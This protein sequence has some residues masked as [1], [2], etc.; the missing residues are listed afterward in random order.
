M[1]RDAQS[2]AVPQVLLHSGASFSAA[3]DNII[4]PWVT[5]VSAVSW[6]QTRPAAVL[7]PSSSYAI[8]LRKLVLERG[9]ALLGVHFITPTALRET[10]LRGTKIRIPAS[11][12]LRLLLSIV[13]EQQESLVAAKSVARSPDHLLRAIEQIGAAG[14]DF[15]KVGPSDLR[16]I[17]KHFKTLVEQCGFQ[18]PYQADRQILSAS[19]ERPVFSD[20]LVVG[21]NG[22]HWPHWSLL[23]AAG[24]TSAKSTIVLSDPRDEARDLDET[25]VGTWEENFGSAIPI[26]AL[27]SEP[28][29]LFPE[30]FETKPAGGNHTGNLP[31]ETHFLVGRD[32]TEQAE[33]ITA[34]VRH[35]LAQ[36]SV[37]RIGIL[38]PSAGAL[39]R[40]VASS[41]T[42]AHI[43]HHDAIAHLAPGPLDDDAWR[44]WLELQENPRLRIFC[45]FVRA[46]PDVAQL[47]GGMPP[48]EIENILRNAYRDLLI[49]D[50]HLL[51]EFCAQ[52]SKST[53]AQKVALGLTTIRFLPE[54]ATLDEYLKSTR[55]IFVDFKWSER[56]QGVERPC[57]SWCRHVTGTFSRSI[58]LRWLSE[59]STSVSPVRDATG[60]HPYSRVQLL[61]YPHA[62]G[63]QWSHLIFA[64]LNEGLW[65][66]RAEESGFLDDEEV[67]ALNGRIGKLN[68]TALLRGSQGE[69]HSIVAEGK[70]FCFGAKER[71]ELAAR[72]VHNLLESVT[73][74]IGVSANLIDESAPER[75][76]NPSEFFTQ[77]FF[78]ARGEALSQ[79]TMSALQKQTHAWLRSG[80]TPPNDT[81][82]ADIQQTA[83]AYRARRQPEKPFSEYEFSLRAPSSREITIS[84]TDW[85]KAIKTPALIWMKRFLGVE[86]ED[87]EFV[88]WIVATGRWVHHW[89]RDIATNSGPDPFSSFPDADTIRAG[90]REAAFRFRGEVSDLLSKIDRA[91]PEWWISGW[92]Q[93][94]YVAERL[95]ERL[96]QT[97]N[98]SHLAT[99]WTLPR[100]SL[101]LV[102]GDNSSAISI[103]GRID[104]LLARGE[105]SEKDYPYSDL[106][107]VDYK[108]G[109]RKSLTP[110]KLL[111]GDGVQLALYALVLRALGATQ[112]GVSVL[113]RE[114]ELDEPQI[115]I[116]I[117]EAQEDFWRSLARMA[118]SGVFGMRGELR[119]EFGFQ[120]DYP[121]STLSID[122]D[123][124]EEKW[125][126]TYPDLVPSDEE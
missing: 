32:V 95:A 125:A 90:V 17:A 26:E 12:H 73:G 88:G 126:L 38:F 44:A 107:V 1:I 118:Q 15:T 110:A 2:K 87:D 112:I 19:R 45:R 55:E 65:P 117:I 69:G 50:L 31:E 113:T 29:T 86:A 114:L 77:L 91:L 102:R 71:R 63:Q 67:G 57:A 20:L 79:A 46:L 60:D 37:D 6:Q 24:N 42:A 111:K 108:T 59:I 48:D 56:W 35:F 10:L 16:A 123:L 75:L 80:S 96:A 54:R 121:L 13:A 72:Q 61:L 14:W 40:I 11:E 30:L 94:F 25:W 99:E 64:G 23:R 51:R 89:L 101:P 4:L 68:R 36:S 100:C 33:G 22:A 98:W 119:A 53:D 84:A 93:A 52:K 76:A 28:D 120:K 116:D 97:E 122:S 105:H 83:I 78:E 8:F 82:S 70:T 7:V 115:G 124:L 43:P 3:W 34:L 109:N 81:K 85:E 74:A 49:D 103:P 66:P 27:R 62:E 21:F 92:R 58:Y 18:F 41:L 39:A 104:L 9:I 106:W 47:F 5:S